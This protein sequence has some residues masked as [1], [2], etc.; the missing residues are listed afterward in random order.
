MPSPNKLMML[1]IKVRIAS[2]TVFKHDSQVI[3][4]HS[5]LLV[6]KNRLTEQ[7]GSLE[8]FFVLVSF[9]GVSEDVPPEIEFAIRVSLLRR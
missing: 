8:V 3:V 5:M 2:N 4:G 9:I 7:V 6:D 1:P